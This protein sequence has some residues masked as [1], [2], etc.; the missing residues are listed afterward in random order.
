MNV[1]SNQDPSSI[2][3]LR[4]VRKEGERKRVERRET[5]KHK[6]CPREKGERKKEKKKY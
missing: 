1:D 3:L 2:T 5:E 6:V 4:R